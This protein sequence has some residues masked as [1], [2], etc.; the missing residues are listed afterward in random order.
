M[1]S[2][3]GIFTSQYSDSSANL[4]SLGGE[5]GERLSLDKTKKFFSPLNEY[6]A[7][8]GS[9]DYRV[10]YVK[11]ISQKQEIVI[12]TPFIYLNHKYVFKRE[13]FRQEDLTKIKL[14]LYVPSYLQ[15]NQTHPLILS[16]GR[17]LDTSISFNGINNIRT[18]VNKETNVRNYGVKIFLD[19]LKLE[20]N[21]FFPIIIERTVFG[22]VP[23]VANF[24]FYIFAKYSTTMGSL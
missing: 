14:N 6:E 18:F 9:I 1:E 12:N 24:D 23:F 19:N 15:K 11:N 16:N 17:F 5:I 13:I 21:E 4:Y 3:L 10:L 8:N 22:P 20:Y 7:T 2:I